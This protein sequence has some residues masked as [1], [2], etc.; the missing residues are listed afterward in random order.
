M[1]HVK[2]E[3]RALPREIRWPL[4]IDPRPGAKSQA[5][6]AI[7]YRHRHWRGES[8]YL[9]VS[10]TVSAARWRAIAAAYKAVRGPACDDKCSCRITIGKAPRGISVTSGNLQWPLI[11]SPRIPFSSDNFSSSNR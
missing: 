5:D 11:G 7:E 2:D 3:P 8:E 6:R 10:P 1:E 4:P 9:P